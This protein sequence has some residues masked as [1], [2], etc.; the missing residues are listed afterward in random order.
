MNGAT[1]PDSPNTRPS[2]DGPCEKPGE[3][4]AVIL[5]IV[6]LTLAIL[7]LVAEYIALKI[8]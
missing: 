4:F 3:A 5:M 7:T 6:G 8:G 1:R 2:C